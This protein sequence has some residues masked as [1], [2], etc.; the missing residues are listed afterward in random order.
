MIDLTGKNLG[1]YHIIEQVG[2]GGMA[3]VYKAYQ[4]GLDRYV[5][6][7]VLPPQQGRDDGYEQRFFRE[8][9]AVA[10][11][12]H[13]NILPIYDVG[14]EGEISYFVMKYVPGRTLGDLMGDSMPLVR[15]SR[16]IEQVAG[17]LD[18]AHSR[19]ILHRDIKPANMLLDEDDWLLLADFGLAKIMEGSEQLTAT[20]ISMGTP[21]YASPEQVEGMEVDRRTDIYSLGIVLF[22]MVT[23]QLPY[24]GNTPMSIMFK[25]VHEALPNPRA[26]NPDLPEGVEAVIHRATA[27]NFQERYAHAGDMAADLRR[28]LD[29]AGPLIASSSLSAG[30]VVPS[31]QNTLVL[32]DNKSPEAGN[33]EANPLATVFM[34]ADTSK[35][36]NR[37]LLLIGGAI[38]AVLIIAALAF[39]LWPSAPEPTDANTLAQNY[40]TAFESAE[41]PADRLQ[42][43]AGL[44]ELEGHQDKGRMLFDSLSTEEQAQLFESAPAESAAQVK[45]IVL[46]TYTDIENNEAGTRILTSMETA[47]NQSTDAAGKSLTSEIDNWLQGRAAAE[48]DYEQAEIAYSVAIGLNNQNPATYFERGQIHAAMQDYTDALADFETV[49]NLN[50]TWN[51]QI[52][53]AVEGNYGLHVALWDI[54]EQYPAVTALVSRPVDTPTPTATPTNTPTVTP[55]SLPTDTPT[56]T[57]TPPPTPS[58]TPTEAPTHA[59]LAQPGS[60]FKGGPYQLVFT[61]WDGGQHNLFVADTNGENEQFLLN[62]AAGPSWSVDGNTIYF[63]GEPGVDHQNRGGVDYTFE[64]I[65]NGLI[66]LKANPLPAN[67]DETVLVQPGGWNEGTAL[68]TNISPDGKVMAYGARPGG[69]LRIYFLGT[70]TLQRFPFELVGEQADWSPDGQQMVYRSGRGGKTGIWISGWDDTGHTNITNSGS[71]SFPAWSPDGKTIAFSREEGSNV[72]IYTVNVDGSNLQ[73][74]TDAPGS[75]TLP[76]FTPGGD[77]VFRSARSGKWAIWKMTADGSEQTEIIADAGVGP[78]WSSSKVDVR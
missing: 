1:Q 15:V 55:T 23:G 40:E 19:G 51:P 18:H 45:S 74:L 68:W 63:Y 58:P 59:P 4:P 30:A 7:K 24:Q 9:K 35:K 49:S 57:P 28:C 20:G 44:L 56:A 61:R 17:A 54:R 70:D 16:F 48:E 60:T 62:R 75:D 67:I 53:Q 31:P 38:A 6:I 25:H 36:S 77:I 26:L 29:G 43:I 69:G 46:A 41:N 27:K 13:P 50:D 33:D 39:M 72:D 12:N 64:G 8:A 10:Q 22:Q 2:A 5:A 71:D 14:I 78:D 3:T 66:Q 37:N 32:D 65:S 11:L 76:T 34:R 52:A 47:L 21:S 42:A 73:R